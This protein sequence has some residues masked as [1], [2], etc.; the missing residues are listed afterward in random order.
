MSRRPKG[1]E[2]EFN[3]A[4]TAVSRIKDGKDSSFSLVKFS[5]FKKSRQSSS[6]KSESY[7][8]YMVL[9]HCNTMNHAGWLVCPLLLGG[10]CQPTKE[11]IKMDTKKGGTNKLSRHIQ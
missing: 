8:E 11:I 3:E 4:L 5:E 9:V 6:L 10:F 2:I 7:I 1:V